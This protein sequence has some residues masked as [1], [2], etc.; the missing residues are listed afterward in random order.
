VIDV[1][2]VE[3]EVDIDTYV[4][5][6]TRVHPETPMPR[7]IVLEDRK[8]PD[9]LDLLAYRDGEAVG[10]ASTAKF[11]G[12]TDG[13][14]AYLT[15]RVV[16]EHRRQGVGTALHERAAEHA[17][18]LAK[19]RFYAVVRDDD[20]G[21]LGYYDACG[22][23]EIGRMQ[24]VVLDVSTATIEAEAPDGVEIV[25]ASPDLERGAYA[26]ALEADADIPSGTPL[27][28]GDFETWQRRHFGP[29]TSRELSLV[30][31]EDGVVVGFGIVSRFTD[32]T[33][34]HSMTGVARRARGRGIAKALKYAQ[35]V[36]ARRAGVRYLR[37]Q[38]DLA[39]AAMRRVNEHFGYQRLF[40]WVHLSG[41]VR[42]G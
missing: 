9:Q 6:R 25:V 21:S 36:A 4:A 7:E 30:A 20:R 2:P 42:S 37:T 40:E 26:V 3:S 41:P 33:C 8:R 22:F 39:N 5:V 1:R 15:L 35:I 28:T 27:S 11:G 10:A 16:A 31:L 24:D 19:T 23:A 18:L 17:R 13:E 38:N 29:L 12:A 34:Q 32:D 14:F